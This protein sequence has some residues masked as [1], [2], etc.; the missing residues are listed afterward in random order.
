MA[1]GATGD[2]G[3]T[4]ASAAGAGEG[5]LAGVGPSAVVDGSEADGGSNVWML[6]V[7]DANVQYLQMNFNLRKIL[8]PCKKRTENCRTAAK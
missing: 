4:L 8:Y 7:G 6:K 5:K 2:A 1:G 3:V